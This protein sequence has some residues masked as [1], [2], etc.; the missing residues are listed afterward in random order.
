MDNTY[1]AYSNHN[2]STNFND[3]WVYSMGCKVIF[4]D[5]SQGNKDVCDQ[6][7][8]T[9]DYYTGHKSKEK[10]GGGT[11][12]TSNNYS[13]TC[14]KPK[15]IQA[16]EGPL[17]KYAVK[18]EWNGSN[19]PYVYSVK[20]TYKLR[21][22][23]DSDFAEYFGKNLITPVDGNKKNKYYLSNVDEYNRLMQNLCTQIST[24]CP[25]RQYGDGSQLSKCSTFNDQGGSSQMCKEWLAQQTSAKRDSIIGTLCTTRGNE[26]LYDCLCT[27]RGRNVDY[28]T[29]HNYFP[30]YVLDKCWYPPCKNIDAS[31]LLTS[32]MLSPSGCP[33]NV[34]QIFINA[35][36][37]RDAK[38]T[39][40]QINM[41]CGGDKPNGDGGGGSGGDGGNGFPTLPKI[42]P[43]VIIIGGIT[44][45]LFLLLVVISKSMKKKKQTT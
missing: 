16:L 17:G 6:T 10:K 4:K 7:N 21:D 19:P 35:T 9:N 34:C 40:N 37:G 25:T 39:D 15:S 30:N 31:I 41:V 14:N 27:N 38:V 43:I 18:Q 20:T 12:H 11:C 26:D 44:I 8:G 5:T 32:D 13:R 2:S 29:V 24:N 28:N 3:P 36:A 22:K 23:I 33:D 45:G 42:P 1:V